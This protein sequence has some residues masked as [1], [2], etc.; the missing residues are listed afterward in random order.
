MK[1]THKQKLRVFVLQLGA[2]KTVKQI[3]SRKSKI[4]RLNPAKE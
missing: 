3:C 1:L 4:F 2:K